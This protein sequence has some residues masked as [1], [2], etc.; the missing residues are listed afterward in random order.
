MNHSHP[1]PSTRDWFVLFALAFVWGFS[2]ILIKRAVAIFTPMQAAMWRM[3]LA[4]AAYLPVALLYW[5]KIQW[6]SWKYYIIVALS[7][8]AIPNFIFSF[9]QKHVSSSLAGVLNSLTPLFTLILGALFFQLSLSKGKISGVLMGFTGATIL[10]VFNANSAVEGNT[11]YAF[12][13]AFATIFYAINSNVVGKY[14]RGHHPAGIA[15][16]AFLLMG[17]PFWIGLFWSGGWEM[18]HT[19]PDGLK[20]VGYLAI[21]AVVSTTVASIIYFT[22][23]QRTGPIFATSVT[24]LLPVV[25]TIIGA[26]DGESIGMW[27]MIGTA[28]ILVGLYLARK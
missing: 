15:A 17:I 13:C 2:F 22:L 3:S 20:G 27:D 24:F 6:K 9:A 7:G 1:P 12:L 28:I 5:S 14:L 25:S 4:T 26:L 11:A 19:H 8:S 21:L 16:G 18:A 10:I 23:M